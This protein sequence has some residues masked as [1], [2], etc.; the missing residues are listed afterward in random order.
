MG[1]NRLNLPN[2][3]ES[4]CLE[5]PGR[6]QLPE[7]SSSGSCMFSDHHMDNLTSQLY[8][9]WY[10]NLSDFKTV[11]EYS[12]RRQAVVF[13]QHGY[14]CEGKFDAGFCSGKEPVQLRFSAVLCTLG[15]WVCTGWRRPGRK[16]ASNLQWREY[17]RP[18][19]FACAYL[20]S[21]TCFYGPVKRE[22]SA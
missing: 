15:F 22:R 6:I 10:R 13:V 11:K 5:R 12:S 3:A 19:F 1:Q 21:Q 2:G 18:P 4:T 9:F 17:V 8:L 20:T 14:R 16:S 7:D